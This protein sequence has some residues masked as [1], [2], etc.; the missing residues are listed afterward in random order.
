MEFFAYLAAHPEVGALLSAGLAQVAE[1]ENAAIVSA[2]DFGQCARVV[3]VGGGRGD[4]LATVLTAYPTVR[5]VLY[6]QPQVAANP[7][8]LQAAGVME[9]CE[10]VP[11]L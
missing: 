2:Y 8:D 4:F 7:A 5:G 6:E 1:P 11:V 10:V 3:D 9:R